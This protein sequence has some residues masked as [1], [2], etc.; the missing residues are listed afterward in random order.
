MTINNITFYRLICMTTR[1]S[2]VGC[3]TLDPF[4]RLRFHIANY[5]RWKKGYGNK[6]S[7]YDIIEKDNY[8]FNIIQT[9]NAN[10]ISVA[11]RKKKEAE[12]IK[13]EK[14]K[15]NCINRVIPGR[16]QN[17]YRADNRI[18]LNAFACDYYHSTTKFQKTYCVFCKKDIMTKY[19]NSQHIHTQKHLK[20]IIL[21]NEVKNSNKGKEESKISTEIE[22]KGMGRN[23][24]NRNRQSKTISI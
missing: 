3:T 6:C 8:V 17:E 10:N 4:L 7:S 19:Y 11:E 5:R 12:L 24:R 16:T 14:S 1:K 20:N 22:T 13:E 18:Y 23:D 9:I 2:Y 15:R 21:Y